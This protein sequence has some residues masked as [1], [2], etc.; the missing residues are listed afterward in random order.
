LFNAIV[1]LKEKGYSNAECI[2][3]ALGNTGS[4]IN[5]AGLVMLCAFGGL[6]FSDILSMAQIGLIL[7]VGIFIDAFVNDIFIIPATVSVLGD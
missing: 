6:T 7:F 5:I 2:S 1:E 3:I 4:V